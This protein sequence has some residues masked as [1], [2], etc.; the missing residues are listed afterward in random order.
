MRDWCG[1]SRGAGAL[2]VWFG[3]IGGVGL[4]GIPR[5]GGELVVW[6]TCFGLETL[7]GENKW[8]VCIVVFW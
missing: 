4:F 1:I 6:L 5:V 7:G 8:F 3:E 2:V